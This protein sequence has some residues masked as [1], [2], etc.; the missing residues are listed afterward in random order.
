MILVI[1]SCQSCSVRWDNCQSETFTVSNGVRQ[2]AVAS[3]LYFNVY[4]DDLFLI[5]KD[6]GLGC[7]I[8]DYFYG[9]FGYADDCALLS[10]SREGL[11]LMLNICVKYFSDHGIKISADVITEKSKT[12][13]LAFN[14]TVVPAMLSLYDLVLPWVESAIH[15]GHQITK[16][17]DSSKAILSSK[18]IFNSK[19]HEL[20]Q[21]L[22]DQYPE[23]FISLVQV[24]L[25]SMYGSNLWDLYHVSAE[26][27]F[28]AWNFFIK[29]T[30][31]LPFATHRHIVYNITNKTHLRVA[32]LRRFINFY[33]K[34]ENCSKPELIHLFS[35]Q[36]CD[37]RSVFG[38]N[39]SKICHEF[40][41]VKINDIKLKDVSMP[42]LMDDSQN[43]RIPFLHD[44]LGLHDEP[45]CDIPKIDIT[46]MI[47]FI[48][49][50]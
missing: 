48:C 11:Q 27:M 35:L 46:Q 28:S 36:K 43:W 49:C 13:C 41:V 7:Y 2:G 38:R 3:P 45:S 50:K 30:F 6:S 47:D 18:A 10:P 21:E 17:E 40:N 24:Y 26:K 39:C 22:G 12:K 31:S 33:K 16:D 20:R 14:I 32:L 4:L 29:N 34:L 44:L 8:D 5:M 42:V 25:T 9:L 15:L 19:V 1:Y 37:Q 23:V